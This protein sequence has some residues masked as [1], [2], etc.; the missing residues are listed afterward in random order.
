M[1]AS[2]DLDIR[3]D[4]LTGEATVALV[5]QHLAG[6]H[7]LSPAESVH[8]LDVSALRDPAVTVWSAWRRNDLAGIGAL[9]RLSDTDGELKSMRVTADHLGTGVGRAIL[10]H[11]LADARAQGVTRVWLETG[12]DAGFLAARTLYASEGFTECE[13]F[14]SYRPDPASTFM[15][16]PL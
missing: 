10:R 16:R 12:S 4:D 2:G 5:R 6:M 9:S 15:T 7:E 14:G 3:V 1:P 13:P 8:A 11:I